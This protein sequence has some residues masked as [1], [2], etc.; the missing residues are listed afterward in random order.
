LFVRD[1]QRARRLWLS[2]RER[3]QVALITVT[4]TSCLTRNH[5]KR[6]SDGREAAVRNCRPAGAT[7]GRINSHGRRRGRPDPSDEVL[8]QL[9]R[10]RQRRRDASVEELLD[11]T[12]RLLGTVLE[13]REEF[14]QSA[15][16]RLRAYLPSRTPIRG[17]VAMA[18]F[19][20]SYAFSYGENTRRTS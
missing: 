13:G 18:A 6:F 9:I 17:I 10:I 15:L 7:S 12:A 16:P 14:L 5:S 2:S 19:L 11:R 8:Q 1:C 20:P 3:R 4:K